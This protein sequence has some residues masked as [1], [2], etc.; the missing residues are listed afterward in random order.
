VLD[1]VPECASTA[2]VCL[3]SGES[4]PAQYAKTLMKMPYRH[5]RVSMTCAFELCPDVLASQLEAGGRGCCLPGGCVQARF[6]PAPRAKPPVVVRRRQRPQVRLFGEASKGKRRRSGEG[7]PRP[8]GDLGQ[9]RGAKKGRR[10]IAS[11]PLGSLR[12]CR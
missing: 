7:R 4:T 3:H 11:R 5:G 1:N 12:G 6:G 8:A 9:E 2:S 10:Q